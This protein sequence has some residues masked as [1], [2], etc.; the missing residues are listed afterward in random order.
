LARGMSKKIGSAL[1]A[2]RQ[3]QE[4]SPADGAARTAADR[5]P[6]SASHRRCATANQAGRPP[7]SRGGPSLHSISALADARPLTRFS[8]VDL[9]TVRSGPTCTK[10][11]ADFGAS[12]LRVERPGGEGH[13]RFFYDGADLHR[14]K[15]SVAV[16]LQDER[17]V[18]ILKRLV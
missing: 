4:A 9:S 17:G 14:N 10:I 13:E 7:S 15:R 3:A 2:P 6:S 11:L 16:N 8:V 12:V 1:P 18:S 5:N